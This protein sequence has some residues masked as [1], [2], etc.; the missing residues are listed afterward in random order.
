MRSF[1]STDHAPWLPSPFQ[2]PIVLWAWLI[3][4]LTSL[5]GIPASAEVPDQQ[6][7][8]LTVSLVPESTQPTAGG[9]VMLAILM[10]PQPGWHGYWHTPGDAGFAPKLTWTLPAGVSAGEAAYPLPGLL[11]IDGLM[12]HVY[13]HDYAILVP[14]RIARDAAGGTPLPVRLKL[15]YLV[16][17]RQVCV[18]ESADVSTKLTIGAGAKDASTAAEF[19]SW[20][21]ALPT[22]LE[23]PVS[24]A[25][26]DGKLRLAVPLADQTGV[27]DPHL[28]VD[29][30]DIVDFSAHQSFSRNGNMLVVETKSGMTSPDGFDAV[31]GL[32]RTAGIAFHARPG[33]VPA[34]GEPLANANSR[35]DH[36]KTGNIVLL[37]LAAFGGAVLG[38]LILNVMPCVF[39]ILSLKA[40]NLARSGEDDGS[41]QIEALAYSAG[42]ILVCV[43]LGGLILILRGAGNQIGWAFQLQS[44][45][46]IFAL[47]LLVGGIA[48]NLAGLFELTTVSA[49]SGLAAKKGWSGA[50]WTGAL[51]AFVATPC[52][53]PFMAAALG[54]ALVLP[55]IAAL[56]IFV[57]LGIGLSLPFLAIGFVPA[58]RR[59]LPKPGNWMITF[60]HALAIPM[61]VTALG[62]AWVIGSQAGATGILLALAGMLIF[63]LGLWGTGLRQRAF[64][65]Y[66]WLPGA[67]MLLLAL[68]LLAVLPQTPTG[69][70]T[71]S[72][73]SSASA[74]PFDGT[75][76]ATLR[77][78]GIPVFLYLTADWC[79]SC[80]VNER[81]AIDREATKSAFAKAGVV[82]MIGDWT[83]GDA[84]ITRF[85]DQHGRSGVPL[86][87]WYAPN[88]EAEVLPQV[89]S[90][91]F[92]INLA[93]SSA[94]SISDNR[95]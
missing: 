95:L 88:K 76:L 92:L 68:P 81:I 78:K 83:G 17:S 4:V 73:T 61:F 53:G 7:R 35:A 31:L 69:A 2:R 80:K 30:P 10:Q 63:S 85:L 77:A 21:S 39:P 40:L 70:G 18:P 93:S 46:V 48:F 38:G 71:R 86:Y 11:L 8:H 45:S 29:G 82:T 51:A 42:V 6:Q 74:L 24:F 64:K 22:P 16:C 36:P 3:L 84:A 52:T 75:K 9:E 26:R 57:G 37:T 90:S 54:A 60:R 55:T 58:I 50:F 49:G 62:L 67:A 33:Q 47:I 5:C 65:P 87:L 23:Q 19:A 14:L 91:Q 59:A 43:T 27:S 79:L 12:N 89:L 66:A 72:A 28:F 15:A 56:L 32:N 13:D 1:S 94:Q 44:P 25:I 34:T 20:R 41:A